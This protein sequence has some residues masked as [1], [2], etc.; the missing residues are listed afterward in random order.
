MHR[1][2]FIA[3]MAFMLFAFATTAEGQ[4]EHEFYWSIYPG[5]QWVPY[6]ENAGYFAEEA[7]KRGIRIKITELKYEDSFVQFANGQAAACVMTNM[8]AYNFPAASGLDVTIVSATDY[9]DGND[10]VIGKF[11]IGDPSKL[12][13]G[14]QIIAIEGTVSHYLIYQWERSLGLPKGHFGIVNTPNENL[15]MNT[16][17]EGDYKLCATWNPHKM[18]ILQDPRVQPEPL[19]DSSDIPGH[20][21]D[22]VVV[23]TDVVRT[24]PEFVQAIIAAQYRALADMSSR[25]S[26]TKFKTLDFMA[27]KAGT[28]TLQEFRGQLETT[29]MFYTPQGAYE[30]INAEAFDLMDQMRQFCAETGLLTDTSDPDDVA[31]EFTANGQ[32]RILGKENKVKLRFT[33]VWMKKAANGEF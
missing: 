4:K 21:M 20:I 31:I 27:R 24:S 1:R 16:F 8:E 22:L 5:W 30:W 18:N 32:V 2:I 17:L 26:G 3:L 7:S 15:I 28:E 10:A 23:Q 9:S 25:I 33:D 6:A 13:A 11:G 12:P 19:F 29:H 14:T